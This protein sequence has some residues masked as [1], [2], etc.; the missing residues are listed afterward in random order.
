M[1][2]ATGAIAGDNSGTFVKNYYLSDT[3]RGI[4]AYDMKGAFEK[5][6]KGTFQRLNEKIK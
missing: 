6:D 1:G 5:G 2:S 4:N 3:I